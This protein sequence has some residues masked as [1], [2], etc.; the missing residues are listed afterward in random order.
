[1]EEGYRTCLVRKPDTGVCQVR[2][3]I[4]IK[5]YGRLDEHVGSDSASKR[6]EAGSQLS[7]VPYLKGCRGLVYAD[8]PDCRDR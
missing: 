7:V 6:R 3:G 1:M 5:Q 2:S 4:R 8:L